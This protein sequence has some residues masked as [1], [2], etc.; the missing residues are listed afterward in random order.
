MQVAILED[1]V[2]Q[3][4]GVGV[5]I[6][7]YLVIPFYTMGWS[8]RQEERSRLANSTLMQLEAGQG[9]LQLR[10]LKLTEAIRRGH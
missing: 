7:E 2:P 6:M 4:G 9:L 3:V 1:G 5:M 10:C 8:G